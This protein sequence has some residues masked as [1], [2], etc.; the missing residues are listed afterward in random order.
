MS[1][2]YRKLARVLAAAGVMS[3]ALFMETAVAGTS[4]PEGF[5]RGT[6]GGAGGEVVHVSTPDQLRHELCRSLDATG[7]CGDS[8]PRVV[9][10]DTTIDFRGLE[11]P[12]SGLGCY[13]Y[14]NKSE[15]LVCLI[16]RTRTAMDS[17]HRK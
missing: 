14:K 7:H 12:T 17:R 2:T 13:P 5:G 16:T 4:G 15:S 11:G 6:T 8:M 10:V 9:V 1:S 3:L